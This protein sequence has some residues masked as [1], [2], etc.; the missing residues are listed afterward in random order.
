M[1]PLM[2]PDGQT[3]TSSNCWLDLV[4]Q[5]FNQSYNFAA[6]TSSVNSLGS[7]TFTQANSLSP[8]PYLAT[9]SNKKIGTREFSYVKYFHSANGGLY[10]RLNGMGEGNN[11]VFVFNETQKSWIELVGHKFGGECVDGTD[12]MN[13][14]TNVTSIFVDS[15]DRLYVLDNNM[16]RVVQDDGKMFTIAGESKSAGDSRNPLSA[17]FN[18]LTS[19]DIY[20]KSSAQPKFV[21]SDIEAFR[22]R[23]FSENGT[24][25]GH[26]FCCF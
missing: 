21:V 9:F 4:G 3:A 13:C 12:A 17:R 26:K 16:V 15:Q 23:E 20:P 10:A 1:F 5:P 7:A 22:I 25:N 24:I 14:A 11:S 19:F 18:R 6:F 8:P 2:S